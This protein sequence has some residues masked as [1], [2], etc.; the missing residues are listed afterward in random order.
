MIRG[1]NTGV[2]AELL[3]AFLFAIRT[4]IEDRQ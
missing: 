1:V 4:N 3:S 2:L